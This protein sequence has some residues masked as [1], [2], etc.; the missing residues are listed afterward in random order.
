MICANIARRH[1]P[2]S[3]GA[4]TGRVSRVAVR[5]PSSCTS[6]T[7][8]GTDTGTEAD[9]SAGSGV[10]LMPARCTRPTRC[11]LA[12]RRRPRTRVEEPV[13]GRVE[14]VLD[15]VGGALDLPQ[16]LPDTEGGQQ[17][18]LGAGQPERRRGGSELIAL[19]P[20]GDPRL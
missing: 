10:G 9:E 15:D 17:R 13:L 12:A 5:V 18:L 6:S 19:L 11:R 8:C 2:T 1:A 3:S 14:L 4:A 16:P 7:R 20:V